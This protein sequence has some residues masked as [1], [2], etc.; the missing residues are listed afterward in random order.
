MSD[1]LRHLTSYLGHLVKARDRHAV[2]SPFVY[3]LVAQ[4]LRP[5]DMLP[6]YAEIEQ[7]RADLLESDQT[8]RVNDLGAGSRVHDQALRRVADMARTAL[9]PPKQAQLLFRLARYLD[10]TSVLELGTSFGITTLYL[11]TGADDSEVHTIEGCPQTYRIAQH[12]FERFSRTNIHAHLGSFRATLPGVLRRMEL[13]DLV[14]IDGHHA[15][16]PTLEYFELCLQHA[17]N[18]TVLV[19]DDIHWSRGM[20]AAW[21]AIKSHPGVTVTIDLYTMGLVFLRSEQAKEHFRLRY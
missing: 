14:F 6:A 19:L 7:A 21:S 4:V 20:E 10:A 5:G 9:K 3:D 1:H 12:Q 8:I 15:E 18:D 16:R 17:H 13:L 2:H 11:S